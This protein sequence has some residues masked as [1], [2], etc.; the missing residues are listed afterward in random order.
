[1]ARFETV[2]RLC[3]M[4]HKQIKISGRKIFYRV[5]GGGKPVMLVH[6]FGET[7]DVWENQASQN[8]P[9]GGTLANSHSQLIENSP[10]NKFK[11]IIPDLPGSGQSEMIDDMSME[12]LAEV[13]KI[14]IDKESPSKPSQREGFANT[15]S[16]LGEDSTQNRNIITSESS[17]VSPAIAREAKQGGDLE[18]AILIGHSMG[19]YIALAF[20][21]KY[22]AML[23]AF[24]LFH[25][26][27]FPDSEEKKVTRRK[28]IEFIKEHGAF[29]FL[30]ISTPNLFSLETKEERTE[31]IKQFIQSLNNFSAEALVSYYESMMKRPDRTQVL[32]SFKKPILFIMGEHDVAV[33]LEDGLKLCHLPEKAYIH[34]LHQSGHMGML[35]EPEK[36][37]RLLED[38]LSEV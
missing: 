38:F 29:E 36:S 31:L 12:G 37:N 35:E 22:G 9:E 3:N 11:F 10:T 7:G 21:E 34:I 8:P 14:I 26:S 4:A 6:G 15:Q 24:G 17:K 20:A 18:E 25:S 16:R 27:A 13:L 28:G 5:V 33:P 1:M 2:P 30:K 23:A 32:R 19:G